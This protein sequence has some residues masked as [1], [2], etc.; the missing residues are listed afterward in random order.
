MVQIVRALNPAGSFARWMERH[1]K[2]GG[3][4]KVPR[5]MASAESLAP[6]LTEADD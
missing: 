3:Q 4:N 5:V 2:L 1:G 6:L